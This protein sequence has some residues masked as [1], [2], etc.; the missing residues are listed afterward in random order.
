MDVSCST[1]SFHDLPLQEALAC[2]ADCG[3]ERVDL[4]AQEGGHVEPASVR[5]DY[6]TQ[7][8]LIGLGCAQARLQLASLFVSLPDQSDEEELQL[9]RSS[10]A[11]AHALGLS[12][13]TVQ[14]CRDASLALLPHWVSLAVE[15]EMALRVFTRCRGSRA[16]ALVGACAESQVT[17]SV[18]LHDL[19]AAGSA[20]VE[21][22]MQ[23][24][25]EV[26]VDP[27]CG[28]KERQNGECGADDLSFLVELTSQLPTLRVV[29]SCPPTADRETRLADLSA[30]RAALAERLVG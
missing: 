16:E 4:V 17:L 29:A 19:S 8:L 1:A 14:P 11:L 27:L 24:V 23:R 6:E 20:T 3:F 10:C 2:A 21:G 18:H 5:D 15:R 9:L 13:L 28:L 12:A 7:H 25:S 26:S 30:L 22:L